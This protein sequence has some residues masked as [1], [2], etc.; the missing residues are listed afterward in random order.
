MRLGDILQ[1]GEIK[2]RELAEALGISREN[3][4]RWVNGHHVPAGD[5]TAKILGFINRPEHLERLGRAEPFRFEELFSDE[6]A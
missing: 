2:Q 3:V 1:R 5:T 4:S 6:A